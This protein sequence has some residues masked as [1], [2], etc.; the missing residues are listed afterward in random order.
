MPQRNEAFDY[1]KGVLVCLM[2]VY[3]LMNAATTAWPEAYTYIRCIVQ[4]ALIQLAA[5]LTGLRRWDL[6]VEA[7]KFMTY[8]LAPLVASC[9]TRDWMRTRLRTVDR[10][11]LRVP[12]KPTIPLRNMAPD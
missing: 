5:R 7:A 4:I 11:R 9:I 1:V 2:V 8:T 10:I 12:P 6:G 3:H